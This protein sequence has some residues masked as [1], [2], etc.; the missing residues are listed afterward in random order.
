MSVPDEVRFTGDAPAPAAAAP[1]SSQSQRRDQAP[2]SARTRPRPAERR[3]FFHDDEVTVRRDMSALGLKF[4]DLDEDTK[5]IPG[6]Q[7]L[8]RV[9]LAV[10]PFREQA[11]EAAAADADG[12]ESTPVGSEGHDHVPSTMPTAHAAALSSMRVAVLATAH[13]GDVRLV[14]LAPGTAA[15]TGAATAI[16][17]PL[18]PEDAEAIARLFGPPASTR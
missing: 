11:P 10:D 14:P 8:G 1:P 12:V 17:V 4:E 13:E 7:Q 16:L 18:T 5:V 15:P 9:L 6:R 3:V 2:A